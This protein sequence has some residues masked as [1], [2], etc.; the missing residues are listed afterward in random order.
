VI[1][2]QTRNV[3]KLRRKDID[4]QWRAVAEGNRVIVGADFALPN[5]LRKSNI[6][7]EGMSVFLVGRV[8]EMHLSI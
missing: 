1:E 8:R 4:E 2:M 6:V 5:A 3:S 7:V